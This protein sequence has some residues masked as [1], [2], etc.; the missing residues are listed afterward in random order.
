MEFV[1]FYKNLLNI[2]TSLKAII[3][4]NLVPVKE[5][6]QLNALK[7]HNSLV[8]YRQYHRND[9]VGCPFKKGQPTFSSL[10]WMTSGK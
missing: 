5:Y 8:Y 10:Y 7:P 2:R 3:N 6:F 4:E 9:A 1:N